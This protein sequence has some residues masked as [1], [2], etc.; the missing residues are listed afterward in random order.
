M[1]EH[2][3]DAAGGRWRNILAGLGIPAKALTRKN[4]PCP[5]CGG[6]DRF[7]F[8]D[9][10]GHGTWI[11]NQC[12]T[13][14]GFALLMAFHRDSFRRVHAEVAAYLHGD[15]AKDMRR[16]AQRQ[17]R[18]TRGSTYA[19]SIEW[20]TSTPVRR[21]GIVQAYLAKRGIVLPRFPTCLR[22]VAHLRHPDGKVFPG[23][24]ALVR[25]ADGTVV[26]V[27]RTY[28]TPD[29]DK[30]PVGRVRLFMPGSV[31]AG[32]AV[33]LASH[34]DVLGIAEGIETAFSAAKLFKVPVWAALNAGRLAKWQPPAIVKRVSIFADNDKNETGQ[35]AA[36]ELATRLGASGLA[37]SVLTPDAV[38]DWNDVLQRVSEYVL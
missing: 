10:D 1:T 12:G 6:K 4:C 14:D 37:V 24:L 27:H 32:S 25:T 33:R 8:L 28:L 36:H 23:M 16:D 2:L 22:E 9:T 17:R 18:D 11:C 15:A 29:G 34:G 20:R 7:R 19:M 26:N 3:R 38:G 21:K 35:R 31:P 13:G 5:M 30:A